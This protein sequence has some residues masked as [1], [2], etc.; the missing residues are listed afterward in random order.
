MDIS[1][2]FKPLDIF[3]MSDVEIFSYNEVSA[4][5]SSDIQELASFFDL[6]AQ[7]DF[8]DHVRQ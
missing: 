5:D 3:L 4:L 8:K 2:F 1:R 7:F 6:L